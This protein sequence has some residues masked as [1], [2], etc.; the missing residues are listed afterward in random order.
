VRDCGAPRAKPLTPD[1]HPSGA[2]S[3]LK[4]GVC[5]LSRLNREG[6]S[7]AGANKVLLTIVEKIDKKSFV[8]RDQQR[9]SLKKGTKR[10]Y[11]NEDEGFGG[12]CTEPTLQEKG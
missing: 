6:L 7:A 5:I 2:T 4:V 10:R 9:A 1:Q 11:T 3:R 12:C 8:K